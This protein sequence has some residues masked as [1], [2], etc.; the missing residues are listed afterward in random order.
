MSLTD[1]IGADMQAMAAGVDRAQQEAAAVDQAIEQITARSV[2]SG[3]AGIA[4]GLARARETLGQARS[5]LA[6]AD[7]VL[8]EASRSLRA[9]PQ[10]SS[11]QETIAALT[12]VLAALTALDGHVTSAGSAV[13]DTRRLLAAALQGGQPGPMLSRLQQVLQVLA[14]V[15]TRRTEARQHVEAVLALARQVG[16]LGN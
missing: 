3:F 15:R 14:A 2:A 8:G 7:G 4:V 9:V 10:Q 16:E 11:P 6:Q 1:T 5:W 12:P 13:D